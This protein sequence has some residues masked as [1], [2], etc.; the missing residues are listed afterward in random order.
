MQ[1][2]P[3]GAQDNTGDFD[4]SCWLHHA[5]QEQLVGYNEYP[6]DPANENQQ[7]TAN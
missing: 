4:T 7:V 6:E 2:G 3:N 5:N 1:T